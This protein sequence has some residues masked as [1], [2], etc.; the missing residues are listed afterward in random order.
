VCHVIVEVTDLVCSLAHVRTDQP[1]IVHLVDLLQQ[2]PAG[3]ALSLAVASMTDRAS[4]MAA[5]F[6]LATVRHRYASLAAAA[7]SDGTS[8]NVMTGI[9]RG[10][11]GSQSLCF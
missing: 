11:C 8:G 4:K 3:D 9:T 7:I 6:A 2:T 5:R 10:G 1:V